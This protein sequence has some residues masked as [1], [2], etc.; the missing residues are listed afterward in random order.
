MLAVFQNPAYL[1]PVL[2][3]SVTYGELGSQAMNQD[4]MTLLQK[5]LSTMLHQYWFNKIRHQN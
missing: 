4:L 1:F 5:R 3:D 2:V